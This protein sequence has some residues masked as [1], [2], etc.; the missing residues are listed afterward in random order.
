MLALPWP[1]N[2]RAMSV[3]LLDRCG[4]VFS[5]TAALAVALLDDPPLLPPRPQKRPREPSDEALGV[6][7]PDPS[8]SSSSCA[9]SDSDSVSSSSTRSVDVRERASSPSSRLP[10]V[11]EVR[12]WDGRGRSR[13]ED[14]LERKSEGTV[15]DPN[16]KEQQ[17]KRRTVDDPTRV[18]EGGS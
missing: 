8:S 5:D 13:L 10:D 15:K 16:V 12:R 3:P 6:R 11:D 1:T 4:F 2:A 9:G 18:S 17:P 14:D 7:S